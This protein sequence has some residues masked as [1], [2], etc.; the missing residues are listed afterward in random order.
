[1]V[2]WDP[3]RGRDVMGHDVG[4]RYRSLLGLTD[5]GWRTDGFEGWIAEPG[6]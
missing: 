5:A 3:D 4:R 2:E 1:V 6:F